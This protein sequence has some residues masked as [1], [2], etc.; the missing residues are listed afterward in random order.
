VTPLL[1]L[2]WWAATRSSAS[3]TTTRA[4]G[5]S[6]SA[7]AVAS[8][9]MPPPITAKS[10]AFVPSRAM[11]TKVQESRAGQGPWAAYAPGQSGCSRPSCDLGRLALSLR[12]GG[13]RI[14]GSRGETAAHEHEVAQPRGVREE[15]DPLRLA[16]EELVH[17]PLGAHIDWAA[18]VVEHH[19]SAGQHPWVGELETCDV[20]VV[21]IAVYVHE[22]ETLR[23][24]GRQR[25]LEEPLDHR[26]PVRK[27]H[28]ADARSQLFE[29]RLVE[30]ALSDPRMHGPVFE[31]VLR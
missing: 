19:V 3:S 22:G 16:S 27:A 21:E 30:G 31:C 11:A 28:S 7:I 1:W 9:T 24:Q 5:V 23:C 13:R 18:I 15:L 20:G 8:P 29:R 25:V 14:L 26:D 2:L 4:P 17:G 10:Q 12:R 6:H